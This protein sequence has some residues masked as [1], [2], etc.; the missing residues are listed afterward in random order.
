[1]KKIAIVLLVLVTVILS[2]TS[3]DAIDGIAH[4]V[5]RIFPG[6][7]LFSGN[8]EKYLKDLSGAKWL[9]DVKAQDIVSVKTIQGYAGVAPGGFDTIRITTDRK[10]IE[11]IV[12]QYR[13]IEIQALNYSDAMV[14]GGGTFN[15]AF[16]FKDGSIKR[17]YLNNSIFWNNSNSPYKIVGGAPRLADDMN[18]EKRYRF[19]AYYRG[20][21]YMTDAQGLAVPVGEVNFNKLEIIKIDKPI[22]YGNPSSIFI[23]SEFGSVSLWTD[24]IIYHGGGKYY[25]IAKGTIMDYINTDGVSEL[26]SAYELK[27]GKNEKLLKYFGKYSSGAV[28]GMF[29]GSNTEKV[30]SETVGYF[31]FNYVN[32]NRITVLY[33]GEFYTLGEAY[34]KGYITEDNLRSIYNIYKF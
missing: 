16:E 32:G 8:E 7:E 15:I 23:K 6:I 22:E 12:E 33:D 11:T 14:N 26:I 17:F 3:C 30:K 24:N 1:M 31:S 19:D 21:A 28:V 10:D 34:E 13:S 4:A 29:V 25:Q 9:A 18:V 20:I 2:I 27:N 5:S